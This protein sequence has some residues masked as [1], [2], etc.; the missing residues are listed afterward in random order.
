[1]YSPA[2]TFIPTR[3]QCTYLVVVLQISCLRQAP[4]E[5]LT[6]FLQ[7]TGSPSVSGVGQ[8]DILSLN[9]EACGFIVPYL[10]RLFQSRR[11]RR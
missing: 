5:P 7:S 3:T 8:C 6:S 10:V 4:R 11:F 2:G 9:L 1:M